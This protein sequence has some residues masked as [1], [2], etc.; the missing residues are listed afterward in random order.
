M[1]AMTGMMMMMMM[2]MMVTTMMSTATDDDDGGVVDDDDG[3]AHKTITQ[4]V[5]KQQHTLELGDTQGGSLSL[6]RSNKPRSGTKPIFR[7]SGV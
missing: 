5:S 1:T 2:M 3:G 4:S 6:A 7:P